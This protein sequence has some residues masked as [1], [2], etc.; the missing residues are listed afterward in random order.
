VVW[1]YDAMRVG[2]FDQGTFDQVY[3]RFPRDFGGLS[4]FIVREYQW[5][6]ARVPPPQPELHTE[7]LYPW[8]AAILGYNPDPRYTVAQVGPGFCNSQFGSGPNRF[9]IDR[10]EGHF[11]ERALEDALRSPHA[12]LA[13]ETW[14]EL[15]EA[16]GILET[17]EYGR[18]YLDLTRRYADLWH[19]GW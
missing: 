10:E 2:D 14:N 7:G 9:C 1:L 12:I 15:G 17:H 6:H 8:G 13:V 5:L 18:R 4:P 16:S 19:S 3:A 11:Y